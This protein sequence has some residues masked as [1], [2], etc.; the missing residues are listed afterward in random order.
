MRPCLLECSTDISK[1]HGAIVM[2]P[3]SA[4]VPHCPDIRHCTVLLDHVSLL[5]NVK[6]LQSLTTHQ[7]M[8]FQLV[9]T[10]SQTLY[11]TLQQ[12]NRFIHHTGGV[13]YV[14]QWLWGLTFD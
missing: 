6:H 10:Y 4:L 13:Q 12:F 11:F 1:E 3:G 14:D 9:F 8:V 5:T 7:S 2:R